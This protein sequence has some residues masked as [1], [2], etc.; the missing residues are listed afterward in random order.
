MEKIKKAEQTRSGLFGLW[1]QGGLSKSGGYAFVIAKNNGCR[2]TA[3]FSSSELNGKHALVV[4]KNGYYVVE[5][6]QEK[7]DWN[8][9]VYRIGEIS[10][11]GMV[12]LVRKNYRHYGKWENFVP[13]R[14]KSVIDVALRKAR[15]RNCREAFYVI[16]SYKQASI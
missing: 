12:R 14:L 10:S 6:F 8:V 7:F 13:K 1:E 5:V 3:I 4:I 16:E 11:N 9:D 2:P 15:N